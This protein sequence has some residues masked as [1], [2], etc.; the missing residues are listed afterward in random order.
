MFKNY[1]S[2]SFCISLLFF[3]S[4][5]LAT[6]QVVNAQGTTKEK[7]VGTWQI[8]QTFADKSE[9]SLAII[10]T[11]DG[12]AQIKE[13]DSYQIGQWRLSDDGQSLY[14]KGEKEEEQKLTIVASDKQTL[15]Y[16]LNNQTL[17]FTK[18][19]NA[20]TDKKINTRKRAKL[21]IGTWQADDKTETWELSL[22]ED[23]TYTVVEASPVDK[24]TWEL[25]SDG[26]YLYLLEEGD[27]KE[28]T[29]VA[30]IASLDKQR[31]YL[32]IGHQHIYLNRV[33]V[34]IKEA[35]INRDKRQALL[36]GNWQL[37]NQEN[38]GLR[39]AGFHLLP[40]GTINDQ[41]TDFKGSWQ[42]DATGHFL[43]IK[44][45][46]EE[47]TLKVRILT[48]DEQQMFIQMNGQRWVMER[49]EEE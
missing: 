11:P 37:L 41:E 8:T 19:A 48:L 2:M 22:L 26:H 13:Q 20:L 12:L 17:Y 45:E 43:L 1:C 36:P 4:F 31:L 42:L 30:I 25:S 21:L 5:S 46:D 32:Q 6:V 35:A 29:K 9:R 28:D 40:D 14:I 7:L 34:V 15:T 10:F 27:L 3:L 16:Q 39:L 24:G 44:K 38:L 18:V 23:G 47:K 33:G 49:V